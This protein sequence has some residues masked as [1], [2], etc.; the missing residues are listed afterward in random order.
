M[1]QPDHVTALD[2][3]DR[4]NLDERRAKYLRIL[5][6]KLGF[7]PN[8]IKAYSFDNAKLAT[9]ADF[10]SDLMGGKS[11]LSSLER[12]MIAVVVS[13]INRCYYCLV[14]HGAEVRVLSG[15][16]ELGEMLAMNYRAAELS[17]RHRSMLD[18]AVKLTEAAHKVEEADRQVL[19]D[20]DFSDADIWD[21]SAV[22][23]FFNMTNRM[24]SAVNMM[25]NKEY[26]GQARRAP[27]R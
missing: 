1:P 27:L 17:P 16:P 18:F 4:N 23:S 7:V 22:A 10:F 13:S 3:E 25:P 9:F 12:E 19:R 15:D 11:G 5:Q 14:S 21:I 8:V 6:E 2:I 24:A 20:V 26:H